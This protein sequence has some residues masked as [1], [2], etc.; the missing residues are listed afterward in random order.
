M[1]CDTYVIRGDKGEHYVHFS[2]TGEYPCLCTFPHNDALEGKLDGETIVSLALL[3]ATVAMIHRGELT[4][5]WNY[6]C[7]CVPQWILE[8]IKKHIIT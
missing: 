2:D 5:E 3:G 7:E 8:E 4:D 1:G 6:I